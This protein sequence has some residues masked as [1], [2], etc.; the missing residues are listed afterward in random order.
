MWYIKYSVQEVIYSCNIPPLLCDADTSCFVGM[1]V[2]GFS[3]TRTKSIGFSIMTNLFIHLFL[4]F[5]IPLKQIKHNME[6]HTSIQVCLH[7]GERQQ[8]NR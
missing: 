8:I 2:V 7:E 3:F 4:P 1:C 5:A 6:K